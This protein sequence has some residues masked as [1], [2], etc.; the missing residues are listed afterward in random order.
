M[1]KWLGHSDAFLAIQIN[2]KLVSFDVVSVVVVAMIVHAEYG[3]KGD[4][5]HSDTV[6][7]AQLASLSPGVR[8]AR[9]RL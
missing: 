6:R 4:K 2:K 8:P 1:P 7:S 3:H 9:H 5:G